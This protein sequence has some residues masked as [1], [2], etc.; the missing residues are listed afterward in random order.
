[1]TTIA[2]LDLGQGSR[3][4]ITDHDFD[5]PVVKSTDPAGFRER[6][7]VTSQSPLAHNSRSGSS[8]R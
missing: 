6:Q 3:N 2:D 4:A 5:Q 8:C 1:M 7:G